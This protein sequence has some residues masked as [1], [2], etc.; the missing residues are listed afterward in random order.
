MYA[1]ETCRVVKTL[2]TSRLGGCRRLSDLSG[3]GA[4]SWHTALVLD[5]R[6]RS[7]ARRTTREA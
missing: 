7:R 3:P 1:T 6:L 5:L 2:T 4:G